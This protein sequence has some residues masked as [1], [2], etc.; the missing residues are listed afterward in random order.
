MFKAF[1]YILSISIILVLSAGMSA[2]QLP[3]L[4]QQSGI[5]TGRFAN[6]ITY[7][8][9][10][11]KSSKGYANFALIK[12]GIDN[13]E[14]VRA[15]LDYEF[16]SSKG[17]GYTRDGYISY[18]G[19]AAIFSFED[20]PTFQSVA[21][22]STIILLF[23]LI[24]SS[25][26]EQA[27]VA[28]GDLDAAKLKDRFYLLSLTVPKREAA[29][30]RP[31]YVWNPSDRARFLHYN[32]GC[33]HL[34][35]IRVTYS[36]SRTPQKYMSTPQPLVTTMYARQLGYVL[37]KRIETLFAEKDIPLGYLRYNYLDSSKT[38][39]DEQYTFEAGVDDKDVEAATALISGVL[40][41]L[42]KNGVSPEEFQDAKAHFRAW[43]LE[44]TAGEMTNKDFVDLCTANYLYGAGMASRKEIVNFFS[45]RR[46]S[47]NQDLSMF[48]RFIAALLDVRRNLT[49]QYGT[50]SDSLDTK[51]LER[52]FRDS[53]K[54]PDVPS[55]YRGRAG[56]TLSLYYPVDRR[57]KVKSETTDPQTGGKLWTFNNGM[58]VVFRKTSDPKVRYAFMLRGGFTEVPGIKEGESAFV[59]DMLG[60]YDVGEMD[61]M[62]FRNMLEANGITMDCKVSVSDM[63]IVGTSPA[64]KLNLLFRSLFSIQK[65]RSLN[66][67]TFDYYKRSEALRQEDFRFSTEGINAVID[68]IMCPD[69][70]YP[71]TKS[72][73][74]LGDE[75][76]DN[77]EAYFATQFLKC[78]DG[79]IF[80]EGDLN[81][82]GLQ[83]FLCRI[84]SSF[85]GNKSF[86]V[87]PKLTY[88]MR[89]G[90]STYTVDK[91]D[92]LVGDGSSASVA[93]AAERPFTMQ[94]WCAFRIAVEHLRRELV[95]DLAPIGC[96]F[97]IVPELTLLPSERIAVFINCRPC[98]SEGL[99]ADVEPAEPMEI[100]NRLRE[101]LAR[102]SSTP[103]S[104]ATLK[105][106]KDALAQEMA[107]EAADPDYV[108]DAFLLRNSEGKDMISNYS[109]YLGKVTVDD[110]AAV[111]DAL[112]KGSKV[113]YVIK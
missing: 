85:R 19:G 103:L 68:S 100:M 43:A 69:Y 97:E 27:I 109:T 61:A 36:T 54:A 29:V 102:I 66:R 42:D 80:I 16:L 26:G 78:Q 5:S 13:Q 76:P 28:C 12:K 37:G 110:V 101:S 104:P 96:Y 46:I 89:S 83:K 15:A 2:Q 74:K 33:R 9:V 67:R 64:D 77:A 31:A 70:Y 72:P 63:R 94:A 62:Q 55:T 44:S 57:L 11:N 35:E 32:N 90:W 98:P 111:V 23:D 99:P 75:L 47:P 40:A 86:S 113:E 52:V 14:D 92:R 53:W 65:N 41:D 107:G 21:L 24:D 30:E 18:S 49:V 58:K 17:V 87:R 59:G 4:G 88:Q 3:T 60:L 25:K 39:S 95:R 105:G 73:D 20:V 82:Y 7:Y 71:P 84:M 10:P 51:A 22:D 38:D 45:G 50:P 8:I 1:K 108:M 81:E 56:D 93:M 6:G 34:S 106:L 91:S 112:G 48:N 79:I